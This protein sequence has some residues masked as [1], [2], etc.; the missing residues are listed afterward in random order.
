[1]RRLC[2]LFLCLPTLSLA[3]DF[4]ALHSVTGV[5]SD[6]VLNIRSVPSGSSEIIGTLA[7]DQTGVEVLRLDDSG[8][9]GQVNSDEMAGWASMRFLEATPG[10]S[11]PEHGS[12][13]CGG[14]EPFW[15][16][17]VTQGGEAVFD[18][19]EGGWTL[20]AGPLIPAGGRPWPWAV[21][22]SGGDRT[23]TAVIT[24][25]ACS[26]G[27]SDRE[28]GLSIT[29]V[30]QRYGETEVVNGCCLLGGVR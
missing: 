16:L 15:G 23:M 6:D 7:P 18:S 5:A 30:S 3:Q 22:G 25:E 13:S 4:P 14:T 11:L 9:W 20:S 19:P 24:P 12:L 8:A 28:Y 1:M 29:V 27:M 21:I 10:G 17:D 26:D 2:L